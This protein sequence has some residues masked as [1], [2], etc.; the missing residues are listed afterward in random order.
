[1]HIVLPVTLDSNGSNDKVWVFCETDGVENAIL[2]DYNG[3]I[4]DK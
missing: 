1:M 4:I 3:I 2:S